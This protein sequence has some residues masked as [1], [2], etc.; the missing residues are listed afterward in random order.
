MAE[1][2]LEIQPHEGK[3]I[4]ELSKQSSCLIPLGNK[5]DRYVAFK[6]K[7]TSQKKF[8]VR[9]NVG[10]I[11]QMDNLIRN[12][13]QVAPPVLQRR[14]K[15]LI[16]V[17][18]TLLLTCF[19]LNFKFDKE[20][21]KYIEERKIK[22]VLT[23]PV[24]S[25]S[26]LPNYGDQKQDSSSETTI[27]KDISSAGVEN[28]YL[29]SWSRGAD[30]LED[31]MELKSTRGFYGVKINTQRGDLMVKE[32]ELSISSKL[33]EERNRWVEQFQVEFPF[34][35]DCTVGL[36]ALCN[37]IHMV[38]DSL[39]YSRLCIPRVQHCTASYFLQQFHV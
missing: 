6:A 31:F 35:C 5:T 16:Q 8:C 25:P 7:A 23:S 3:F 32:A 1:V 36:V 11:N 28:A 39:G 19:L 14:D 22:V 27:P 38:S 15:V 13:Q 4:F 30:V 20:S 18:K 29:F 12:S 24:E 26:L 21:G 37:W 33:T 2:L 10:I 9:P 17:K 34:L